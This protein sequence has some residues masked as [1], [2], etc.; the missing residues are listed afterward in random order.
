MADFLPVGNVRAAASPFLF[1]GEFNHPDSGNGAGGWG[2]EKLLHL[3]ASMP[4]AVVSFLVAP[5]VGVQRSPIA[6]EGQQRA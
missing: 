2:G 5:N 6:R 3:R 1:S 4:S